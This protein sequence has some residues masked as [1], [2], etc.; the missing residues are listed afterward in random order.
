MELEKGKELYTVETEV[1]NVMFVTLIFRGESNEVIL[2]DFSP[3][4][5][6]PCNFSI[7]CMVVV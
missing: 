7:R 2:R 4:L 6:D 3:K 1:K 5:K